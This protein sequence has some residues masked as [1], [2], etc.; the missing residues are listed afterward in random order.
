MTLNIIWFV[1]VGVLFTGYFV[2]EGFDL[3]VGILLPFLGKDDARKRVMINSIGPHWDGNEVWL[4]T[5]GGAMFAAFPHWYATL[6]SGFYLPLFLMLLALIV[7]GVGFEFR[8][9]MEGRGWRRFWDWCLFLGSAIPALL[10]GV[11][12]ANIL[13][14]VPID[15]NMNY[16]GGF[17]NLLNPYA[18]LA[19]VVSLLGFALHGA[20]FLS[21]KTEGVMLDSARTAA[22]G[23]WPPVCIAMIALAVGSYLFTDIVAQGGIVRLALPALAVIPVLVAGIFLRGKREGWAFILTTLSILLTTAALFAGLFPRVMVS[24]IDPAF[25]LTI[26]NA[27]SGATTLRVMT[28]VAGIFVP[29][30]L[31]YQAWSYRVFRKRLSTKSQLEY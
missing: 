4:I 2:L 19:G 6:F 22:L 3:G 10:W 11:A 21:L 29:I 24:N 23:L 25:S 16:V 28:I 7:R 31:V 30:V 5:A 20:I 18:L 14:G 17:F 27:A 8:S 12:M 9:K 26:Q 1:L 13:R 15:G